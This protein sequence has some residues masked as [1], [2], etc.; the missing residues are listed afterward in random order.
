MTWLAWHPWLINAMTHFCI[1]WEIFFCVLIWRPLWRPL[2]L[3]GAVV[4]HLGI[5]ACL[6]MW[7][8]GLIM[9][10]GCAAFL[11][12]EPVRRLVAALATGR[13]RAQEPAPI[14]AA[15]PVGQPAAGIDVP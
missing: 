4:M 5:G 13:L 11:P 3:A 1:L 9:L 12:N 8:F 2:L 6:G 7:T 15:G 10:V 14:T